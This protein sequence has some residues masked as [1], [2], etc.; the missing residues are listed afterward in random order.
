M[1][2]MCILRHEIGF[3]NSPVDGVGSGRERQHAQWQERRLVGRPFRKR[4]Q[5]AAR[6]EA[7]II[8]TMWYGIQWMLCR[9]GGAL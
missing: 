9:D 2:I 4:A 1:Q 6:Y 8:H 7:H 3:Y 5:I